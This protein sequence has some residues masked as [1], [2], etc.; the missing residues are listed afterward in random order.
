MRSGPDDKNTIFEPFPNLDVLFTNVYKFL[1]KFSH[2]KV[3][4]SWCHFITHGGTLDL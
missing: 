2:E 3:C 1:C 4:I